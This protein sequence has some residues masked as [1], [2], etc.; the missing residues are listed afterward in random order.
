MKLVK[1]DPPGTWCQN[2][3]ILSLIRSTGAQTFVEIGCGGGDLSLKICE[4]GLSGIGIDFSPAAIQIA[5]GRLKTFL[6]TGRFQLIQADATKTNHE[7]AKAEHAQMSP[8]SKDLGLS[9]MVMEHV[10]DDLGFICNLAALVKTGGHV[11]VGVPGRRDRW[12][13]ED[14]TVGHIRRYDREDLATKM[15]SAGLSDVRVIS[16]AVPVA[17]FLYY[18]GNLL[19]RRSAEVHK[20]TLSL[21]EQ[22]ETSGVR[23]IPFKTVFPTFF[24][25][26]LNRF[27]MYPLFLLQR[28][29][30]DTELGL[31]IIGIGRV[32]K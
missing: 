17:N 28:M 8:R 7:T 3:A 23:D 6:D 25:I 13:I 1:I 15:E 9:I 21:R 31:T 4:L 32:P 11:L 18:V 29:F 27:T 5:K 2:D 10:E 20:K 30:Y 24:R 19:I 16:V 26:F 12:N 14:E 22:T